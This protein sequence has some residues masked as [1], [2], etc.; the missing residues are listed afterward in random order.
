MG[1]LG[2]QIQATVLKLSGGGGS[3]IRYDRGEAEEQTFVTCSEVAP[4]LDQSPQQ[5]SLVCSH[6]IRVFSTQGFSACM[7]SM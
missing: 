7:F 4:W 6:P 3:G 5:L 1:T 2:S